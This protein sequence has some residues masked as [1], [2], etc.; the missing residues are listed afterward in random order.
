MLLAG[1]LILAVPPRRL[2]WG[3]RNLSICLRDRAA[4]SEP[5]RQNAVV[6]NRRDSAPD[7][8]DSVLAEIESLMRRLTD[9]VIGEGRHGDAYP[10]STKVR[11]LRDVREHLRRAFDATSSAGDSDGDGA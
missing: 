8:I 10:S 4:N 3:T 5:A 1:R 11:R 9:F 6:T 2:W 7:D